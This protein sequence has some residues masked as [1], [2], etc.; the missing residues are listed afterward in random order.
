MN[1]NKARH[2]SL[3]TSVRNGKNNVLDVANYILCLIFEFIYQIQ[4][5]EKYWFGDHHAADV[6]D[7]II[8]KKDFIWTI[9]IQFVVIHV[10]KPIHQI[11]DLEFVF[12]VVTFLHSLTQ[13]LASSLG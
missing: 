1:T 9:Q 6:A 13:M 5:S 10:K 3:K 2:L 8:E 4:Q 12:V 7:M 11:V